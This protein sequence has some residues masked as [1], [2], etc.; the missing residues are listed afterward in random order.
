[1]SEC[2][3]NKYHTTLPQ[4]PATEVKT[5]P[6]WGRPKTGNVTDSWTWCAQHAIVVDAEGRE[7]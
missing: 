5:R 1:M 2:Y 4:C 7:R 3:F 6:E